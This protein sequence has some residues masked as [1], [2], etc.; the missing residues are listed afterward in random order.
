MSDTVKWG[1]G[2]VV[3]GWDFPAGQ[4]GRYETGYAVTMTRRFAPQVLDLVAPR[5]GERLLDVACGTG[6]LTHL[7][8]SRPLDRSDGCDMCLNQGAG[9]HAVSQL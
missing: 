6:A 7:A 5:P 9:R 4:D 1:T 2:Q 3:G 8:A